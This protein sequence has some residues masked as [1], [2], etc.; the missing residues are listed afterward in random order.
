MNRLQGGRITRGGC[1]SREIVAIDAVVLDGGR[2]NLR[3]NLRSLQKRNI[4]TF[5]L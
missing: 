5:F 2:N 3:D 1:V 4:Y